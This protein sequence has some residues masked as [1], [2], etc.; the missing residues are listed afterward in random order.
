MI[1][2][3]NRSENKNTVLAFFKSI[4]LYVSG[5]HL[6]RSYTFRSVWWLSTW[7]FISGQVAS[8]GNIEEGGSVSTGRQIISG[9]LGK[10]LCC[11]AEIVK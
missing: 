7:S 4:Q 11:R 9:T 3:L 5:N 6:L 8:V 10:P 2:E 1:S